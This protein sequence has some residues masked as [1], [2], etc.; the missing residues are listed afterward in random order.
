MP[1]KNGGL[2]CPQCRSDYGACPE[3]G[4]QYEHGTAGFCVKPSCMKVNAPI[5]CV[6]G[7]VVSHDAK[8]ILT[9]DMEYRK[10]KKC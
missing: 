3:C 5:D 7:F 6:C 4:T 9:L 10:F 2:C 8:G 1:R